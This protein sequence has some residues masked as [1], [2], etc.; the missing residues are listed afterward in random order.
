[1]G[2]GSI[3]GGAVVVLSRSA[4]AEK[5]ACSLLVALALVVFV[6]VVVVVV[7]AVVVV[8]VEVRPGAAVG[9]CVLLPPV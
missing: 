3:A 6:V 1:M 7:V 4:K 8:V 2:T 9:G 5:M